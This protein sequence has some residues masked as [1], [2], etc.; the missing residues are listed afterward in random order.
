MVPGRALR[1]KPHK[2][3]HEAGQ[4]AAPGDPRLYP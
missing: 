3:R 1:R 2:N 4:Q